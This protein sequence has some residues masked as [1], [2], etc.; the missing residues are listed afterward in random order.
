M[1]KKIEELPEGT[2]FSYNGSEF[3]KIPLERVSCC[4]SYNAVSSSNEAQKI[5]VKQ[6]T[7]VEV[8]D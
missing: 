8:N 4:R 2:I 5:F 1:L 6:G 7:E 3:K